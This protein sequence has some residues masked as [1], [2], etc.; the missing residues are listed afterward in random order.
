V[1]VSAICLGAMSFGQAEGRPWALDEDTSR[2]IIRRALDSGINFIDTA[3]VY[4]GG[5]SEEFVGRA[6][7]DFVQRDDVVLAT[8][9]FSRMRPGPNGAGL[10]RKAI[11][12]EI[13]HSLRRLGVDYVDLYQIHRWDSAT[14]IEETLEALA[15]V[16]RAGKARYI[17]ASSMFAWQFAELQLTA[18]MNGWTRFVSMQNHYNLV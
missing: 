6:L 2:G 14:P 16:V 11:L 10:S 18:R 9:V 4:N 3:N 13:D 5:T 17:G 15:D 8:K 1:Q 12:S 7:R